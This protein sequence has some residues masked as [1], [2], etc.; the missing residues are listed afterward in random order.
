[1]FI[2][3]LSVHQGP[4]FSNPQ[5]TSKY[6]ILRATLVVGRTEGVNRG[7]KGRSCGL[8]RAELEV[9]DGAEAGDAWVCEARADDA[10]VGRRGRKLQ[11]P[12]C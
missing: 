7:V 11:G 9:H 2:P 1:M 12:R 3:L 4:Y 5:S 6:R 10:R 8:L